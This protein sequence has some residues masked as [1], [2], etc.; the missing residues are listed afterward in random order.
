M[1]TEDPNKPNTE[2]SEILTNKDKESQQSIYLQKCNE[3]PEV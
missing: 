2:R 1:I 3:D